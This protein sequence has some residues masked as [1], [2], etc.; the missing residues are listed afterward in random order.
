M[1]LSK[2]ARSFREKES[3]E[4]SQQP[5]PY[6]DRKKFAKKTRQVKKSAENVPISS[7]TVKKSITSSLW[8][9]KGEADECDSVHQKVGKGGMLQL[10]QGSLCSTGSPVPR[11]QS[12]LAGKGQATCR[13]QVV[14]ECGAA[15]G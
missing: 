7:E 15:A 11:D 6:A 9:G 8:L 3:R 10:Q 1:T 5:C 12:S 4:T 14:P 2:K 13:L